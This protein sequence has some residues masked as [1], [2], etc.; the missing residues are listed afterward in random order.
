M[1]AAG[2]PRVLR[3]IAEA[4]RP[5]PVVKISEWAERNRV[6]PPDSP[7]PGPWRNSRT[8]HLVDIMDSMSSGTGYREGWVKKG[9]QL[10]GSASGENFI[11]SAICTAAGSIL[12]VFPTL[13]DA[14]QW[15]L[16]RFEPMRLATRELRKR[17]RDSESK[18]AD[19]TKLRKKFPG[20]VLRLVSAN[21]VG[22][23]KSS[24]IRYVKLEEPDDLAVDVEKQGSTVGLVRNRLKNFGFK[25]RLFGDGTPTNVGSSVIDAEYKRG[26][27][28]KR[29]MRCPH[30]GHAQPLEWGQFTC[31]DGDPL[32]TRYRCIECSALGHEHEWKAGR[33]WI[34]PLG[35]TER[36][37]KEAGYAYWEAT[38][39]GERGV[40]SWHLP[41]FYAPL[42]WRP[43]TE[44]MAAWIAAQG[45]PTKLKEF[46]NNEKAECYEDKVNAAIGAAALQARAENYPLLQC[47]Q[48]GLIVVAGVDTQDNRLAVVIRAY[49]RG[50]ESWGLFHGEIYGNPS[51]PGTWAKLRE[52]LEAPIP[53]A[54]GQ[55]IN[56]DVAFIDS[57][58][59]HTEDVYAFCR[60][61]QLRGHQHWIAIKGAKPIDAPKLSK[62]KKLDFTWRGQ[63]VPGGAE[64]RFIGTQAIKNII[65]GRFLIDRPGPGYYHFPLGFELDYFLQLR[66]E[67][68][69]WRRDKKTGKRALWW[70]GTSE[71]NEA[72]DCEVY[73]YAAFL[74]AMAGRNHEAFWR[75]REKLY[76]PILIADLFNPAA[77]HLVSR[78]LA[79]PAPQAGASPSAAGPT[80]PPRPPVAPASVNPAPVNPAPVTPPP[81]TAPV[82]PVAPVR[83]PALAF[84]RDW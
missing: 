79:P 5:D 9:V 12:V 53:H 68:R 54:S 74:Y 19:N 80:Q 33:N 31:V 50:E 62:P 44:L 71:R 61:A 1:N 6:L 18:S 36:Q 28:R 43:W 35:W 45:D 76:A 49:G 66:A 21:R 73:A 3:A 37:C 57:Q 32:T 51:E 23:L 29:Y 25:G 78:L 10:G 60:D 70:V 77:T 69:E 20:G 11:G 2:L 63:P 58:G 16:A 47:P 42:G 72:W 81:G 30:C 75:E 27:Q 40:A 67:K 82:P 52:L 13:D 17:V 38:A 48:A 7:E 84:A 39:Q 83:A 65:D 24:T 8:P 55:S 56:V 64:V 14:R 15:E 59:H 4:C 41:S 26:D 46:Y 34:R 22:A